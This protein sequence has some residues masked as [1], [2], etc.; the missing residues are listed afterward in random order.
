MKI[1][2]WNVKF[3]LEYQEMVDNAWRSYDLII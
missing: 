3:I 2:V 1:D